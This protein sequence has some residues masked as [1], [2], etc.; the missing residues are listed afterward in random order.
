MSKIYKPFHY[1]QDNIEV[2]DFIE[3]V[4]KHYP[5]PEAYHMKGVK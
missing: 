1:T 2:I 4:T 3:Q 5:T